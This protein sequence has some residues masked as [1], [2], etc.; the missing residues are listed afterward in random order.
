MFLSSNHCFWQIYESIICLLQWKSSL[1]WIKREICTDQAPFIRQNSSKPIY[2]WILIWE[3][4][5]GLLHWIKRYGLWTHILSQNALIMDLFLTNTHLFASHVNWWS[6]VDYCDVFIRCLDSHSDGTHSLQRIH[7][8][9]NATFL[10]ILK[11]WTRL[12]CNENTN[13]VLT[14]MYCV[15]WIN[16]CRK[17]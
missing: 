1:I 9:C 13:G 11:I 3:N 4:N 17:H 2:R 6:G 8:W 16:G 7:W 5:R 15:R 12:I 10:Q 14:T